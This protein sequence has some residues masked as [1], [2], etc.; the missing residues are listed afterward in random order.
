MKQ[1]LTVLFLL[2]LALSLTANAGWNF[3]KY[4]PDTTL[5]GYSGCHGIAVDPDGKVWIQL[6]GASYT[7]PGGEGVAREIFVYNADGTPAPFNKFHSV[8]IGGVTDTLWNSSRGMRADESG[9]IICVQF[10]THY[11]I[12][13]K[14]GEG[15]AKGAPDAN[16]TMISP[17]VDALGEVV[18]GR[19]IPKGPIGIASSDFTYLGNACDSA[20]GYSRCLDVSSDGNDV[21]WCGY[22]TGYGVVV[23]HSDNGS[24]GP[25]AAAETLGV[26][27]ATESICFQPVTGYL[28]VSS[29]SVLTPPV[30]WSN[31]TWYAFDL[32]TKQ[33]VDSLSWNWE[34][35]RYTDPRPRGIA[36]SPGGDTA[37]V[38]AFN[39][40]FAAVQMFA[41]GPSSVQPITN[42]V[43]DKYALT[44]NYPNPFN[45]STK[46]SYSL[47]RAG[48]V[49][50]S[51]YNLLGQVAAILVD[52][53]QNAGGH[54]I[55]FSG[56]GLSSGIYFYR[57]QTADRVI[58]KKMALLK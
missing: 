11:R 24:I 30:G 31:T 18:Y 34:S 23:L 5:Q 13:Y 33:V 56:A 39:A 45:P 7:F 46:I 21:F 27:M 9:N 2:T 32:K 43:P 44:Q 12:D 37:Y 6:Y 4:F 14:T 48:K 50:L 15:M 10:D 40:E 29:G 25:Y 57:L 54:E 1:I 49:N 51:V 8:T 53:V 22:T 38:G 35:G 47:N 36:F 52:G 3:V 41:K 17:G 20:D 26:G 42:T 16:N 58:T 55:V 28:W 19:V